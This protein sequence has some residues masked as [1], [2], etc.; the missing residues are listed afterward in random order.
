MEKCK[1]ATFIVSFPIY[2]NCFSTIDW[3]ISEQCVHYQETL[4]LSTM[5]AIIRPLLTLFLSNAYST[6]QMFAT[7]PEGFPSFDQSW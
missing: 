2:E 4:Y 5:F 6:R 1:F 3:I 7:F